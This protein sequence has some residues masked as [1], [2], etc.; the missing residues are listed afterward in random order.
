MAAGVG[1]CHQYCRMLQSSGKQLEYHMMNVQVSFKH[2]DGIPLGRFLYE[3]PDWNKSLLNFTPIYTAKQQQKVERAVYVVLLWELRPWSNSF[4][5]LFKPAAIKAFQSGQRMCSF[6]RWNKWKSK[7]IKISST[8]SNWRNKPQQSCFSRKNWRECT[9]FQEQKMQLNQVV[10]FCK[11]TMPQMA[12][13]LLV[14]N[15]AE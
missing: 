10:E 5:K 14:W 6:N 7:C 1:V 3:T 13:W 12:K 4:L 2:E 8:Y 15:L 9:G 11:C